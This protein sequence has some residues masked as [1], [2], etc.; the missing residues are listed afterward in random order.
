MSDLG[1]FGA[2]STATFGEESAKSETSGDIAIERRPAVPAVG[3]EVQ[4][5]S[6]EEVPAPEGAGATTDTTVVTTQRKKHPSRSASPFQIVTDSAR[7][8][9]VS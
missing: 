3:K 7:I 8:R 4:E 2:P 5:Q 6:V 9:K 1:S